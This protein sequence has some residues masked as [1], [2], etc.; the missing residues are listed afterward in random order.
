MLKTRLSTCMNYLKGH[1]VLYD[2]GT[3]H[4]YLPIQAIKLGYIKKAYAVD[5]KKG[6]LKRAFENIK[7]AQL[8]ESI[9]PILA[10]GLEAIKDNV[11]VVLMAGLGGNLIYNVFHNTPLPHVK[12]LILQPNNHPE[13]VRKLT[14]E[15]YQIIDETVIIEDG[16][17]Y[18]IIVLEK[19][20]AS[21]SDQ[22]I[23]FGPILLN[24]KQQA[25]QQLLEDEAAYLKRLINEIPYEQP[26]ERH[27]KR[28]EAIK[29][30]LYEW[31]NH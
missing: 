23:T 26:K 10:N 17:P 13:K 21:Y 29:E 16:L 19:G 15:G 24:K 7:D 2:I 28:L 18:V 30:V 11:D 27:Q 4:A 25:Y 3:D 12:R 31:D 20:Q 9:E 14:L 22:A 8:L 1:E 5:N 6:P